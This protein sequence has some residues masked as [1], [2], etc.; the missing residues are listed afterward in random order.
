[1]KKRTQGKEHLLYVG[2]K[3]NSFLK[4]AKKE[5]ISRNIPLNQGKTVKWGDRVYCAVH[6]KYPEC[7][8]NLYGGNYPTEIQLIL[9]EIKGLGRAKLL[10]S[11]RITNIYVKDKSLMDLFLEDK[12]VQKKIVKVEDFT[13]GGTTEGKAVERD[14]GSY[15]ITSGITV[16]METE[17]IMTKINDIAGK[18][19]IEKPK[20]MIGGKLERVFKESEL[21]NIKFSRGLRTLNEEVELK[22]IEKTE[23]NVVSDYKQFK[24]KKNR[25]EA[26]SR[27]LENLDNY[28]G[29][30]TI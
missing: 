28:F 4:E 2:R 13:E 15:S 8:K 3:Y 18:E 20:I 27:R 25:M 16:T 22:E 24:T 23:L 30:P 5:G 11:F 14:C 19:G 1:M 7:D 21:D 26:I 12:T 6:E 9:D 29:K 17:Q 10:C